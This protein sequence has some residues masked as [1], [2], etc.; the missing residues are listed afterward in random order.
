MI[1]DEATLDTFAWSGDLHLEFMWM[2][3]RGEFLKD[4]RTPDAD[5]VLP[6]TIATEIERQSVVGE[7]TS[8]VLADRLE[9]AFRYEDYDNNH[10][11]EDWGDM[12]V[13]VGGLNGYFYEHRLKVQLNYIHRDEKGGTEL[14]NDAV[15]LSFGG[16][17]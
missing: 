10:E 4:I 8:F 13:Y 11:L 16:S 1:A 2:R 5:P 6:P 3:L 14:D 12:V 9:L 15:I 17:I 7:F